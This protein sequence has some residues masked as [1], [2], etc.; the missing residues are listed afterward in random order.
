MKHVVITGV[1]SGIGKSIALELLKSE[2]FVIGTVRDKTDSVQFYEKYPDSFKHIECEL[3]EPDSIKEACEEIKS[4][5]GSNNLFALINNSGIAI[6]GPLMHQSIDEIKNHFEVNLFG[7]INMTQELLPLLGASMPPR[8]TPGRIIN[9]SSTNGK[10]AFP[11][12]GAYS[13]TKFALEAISDALRYELN[14]Y[15]IKV[16]LIEPGIIKTK[17]WDKAEKADISQ[18]KNTDYFENLNEFRTE[19]VKIGREGLEPETV[20]SV[21]K[22]A[23]ETSKP[24]S[25]YVI[26]NKYISEWLL[27]RILP[28]KYLDSIIIK[29]VG[30]TK[31]NTKK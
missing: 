9:M 13:A 18:Y 22:K 23:L 26:T 5:L 10:I 19:F 28:D 14:I 15:G 17:I 16:V 27:P 25:R 4:Y 1:S 24:K 30:L 2:Y 20:S 12:V 21:V 8:K 3:T 7:L 6:G 31:N 11:Y 29:E